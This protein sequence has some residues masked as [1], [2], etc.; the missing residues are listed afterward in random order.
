MTDMK[1]AI[2]AKALARAVAKD[3]IV[4][5]AVEQFIY[6]IVEACA[7]H[8]REVVAKA[9]EESARAERERCAQIAQ[10]EIMGAVNDE[11]DRVLERVVSAIRSQPPSTTSRDSS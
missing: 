3:C 6:Q 4:T 1:K 10:N 2:E 11:C 5:Q 9:R 8:E 7:E